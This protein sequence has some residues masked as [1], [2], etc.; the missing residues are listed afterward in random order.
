M[1][2][3]AAGIYENKVYVGE[4]VY[5]GQ[6]LAEITDPYEGTL[7]EQLAAPRDGTVFFQHKAPLIYA[8]TAAVKLV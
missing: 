6:L 7:L 8:D 1:R 2:C 3:S 5:E 4:E